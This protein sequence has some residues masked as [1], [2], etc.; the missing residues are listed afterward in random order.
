[1]NVHRVKRIYLRHELELG[2]GIRIGN[3]GQ[4]GALAD[5]IVNRLLRLVRQIAQDWE[6]G[7]AGQKTGER[8]HQADDDGVPLNV[9][10]NWSWKWF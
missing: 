2:N 6:D 1:M 8:V 3:E 9:K 7:D 4:T 10:K 5:H